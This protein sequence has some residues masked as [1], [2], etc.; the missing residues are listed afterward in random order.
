MN[1]PEPV[2][3]YVHDLTQAEKDAV[4]AVMDTRFL[5][6]GSSVRAFETAFAEYLGIEHAVCLTSCTGAM[7]LALLALGIG[8]GDEVITTP[9]SFVATATAIMEAGATPVFVDVEPTTG[10]I[11]AAAIEAAITPRTKAILPV[12]LYGLMVDM[13]AVR[14]IADRHGLRVIEDA[15]HCVEGE[16]DGVR[17][18]QLSDAAAFSFY[19]TKN[20]TCG[21][22]G[23]LVCRDGE[24]AEHVRRL[25]HH[26]ITKLAFDRFQQGTIHWDMVDFGWKYNMSNLSAAMLLPQLERVDRNLERRQALAQRYTRAFADMDRIAVQHVPTN[27]RHAHHLY[28]IWIRDGDRDAI[29]LALREHGIECAVNY[30]PIHLMSYFR[31]QRGGGEGQF[32]HAEWIGDRTI[33]LPFYPRLDD[34]T[35]DRVIDAVRNV[36]AE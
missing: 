18:G 33:S 15:A 27:A 12:H 21:E 17:P 34:E 1:A 28:P 23:A 25:S 9:M 4:C 14:E 30:R 5:T 10:N 32:P 35:A 22:G 24:L 2:P 20:L 16:R 26:G 6:T 31:E 13:I 8:A 36:L 29:Y 19:A 11:D 3:F 7:H